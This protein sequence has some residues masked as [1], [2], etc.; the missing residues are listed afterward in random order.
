MDVGQAGL[1]LVAFA[2]AQPAV[3]ADIFAQLGSGALRKLDL[4]YEGRGPPAAAVVGVEPCLW[5]FGELHLEPHLQSPGRLQRFRLDR[6]MDWQTHLHLLSGRRWLS[7]FLTEL[8]QRLT[9]NG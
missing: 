5:N 2:V 4:D 1:P 9:A 7:E 8:R 6:I 3:P